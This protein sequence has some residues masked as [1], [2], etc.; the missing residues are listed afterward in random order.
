MIIQ[1]VNVYDLDGRELIIDPSGR[2]YFLNRDR[3]HFHWM[4]RLGSDII[5]AEHEGTKDFIDFSDDD[6]FDANLYHYSEAA[7]KEIVRFDITSLS[8]NKNNVYDILQNEIQRFYPNEAEAVEVKEVGRTP[9][10]HAPCACGVSNHQTMSMSCSRP[11]CRVATAR[12]YEEFER[13]TRPI[14]L[15][16]QDTIVYRHRTSKIG[17]KTIYEALLEGTRLVI[18]E[19]DEENLDFNLD[20]YRRHQMLNTHPNFLSFHGH[21]VFQNRRYRLL[22]HYERT[23]F[24]V[25]SIEKME[26]IS[27]FN[28]WV[29]DI[30]E[31]LIWLHNEGLSHGNVCPRN[32]AVLHTR[33]LLHGLTTGGSREDDI[34]CLGALLFHLFTRGSFFGKGLYIPTSELCDKHLLKTDP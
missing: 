13:L 18:V 10:S 32:V 24:H 14:H 11:L 7:E 30:V 26:H 21:T 27:C 20:A 22:S 29:R 2:A 34:K 4:A 33:A 15:P 19:E 28:Q 23:L 6:A 1:V 3:R 16:L 31:G 25:I 12:T 9:F 8:S 5:V 17:L